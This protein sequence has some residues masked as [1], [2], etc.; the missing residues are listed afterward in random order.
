MKAD[1][2]DGLGEG[3]WVK[4]PGGVRKWESLDGKNDPRN[5]AKYRELL[6]ER[7]IEP[8]WWALPAD[9]TPPVDDEFTCARRLRD[10]LTEDIETSSN[11]GVA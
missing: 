3:R 2:D 6:E 10:A 4:C 1:E 8:R 11:R 5:R 9:P 7:Y